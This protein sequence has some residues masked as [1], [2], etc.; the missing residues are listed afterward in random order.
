MSELKSYYSA[1]EL[2]EL[3]LA[4]LPTSK[5]AILN[6]ATK[7][8]WESRKRKGKGGGF[9]YHLHSLPPETQKQ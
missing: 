9:E 3:N 4:G 5:K 2:V 6:K 8:M 1:Q 7:E